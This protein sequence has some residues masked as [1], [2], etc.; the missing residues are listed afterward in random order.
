M[1]TPAYPWYARVSG[2]DLSQGDLLE[3]CPV[4]IPL[5]DLADWPLT[6]ANVRLVERDLVIMSQTCDLAA[7][8]LPE[9]L[10][11]SAWSRSELTGDLARP[12]MLENIRKGRYPAFHL[13]AACDLPGLER[14]VRLIDFRGTYAL[15]LAF[16]R[17]RA[18]AAGDRLRRLPPYREHLAQAFARFFM[19]VGLPID[20]PPFTRR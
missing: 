19:R 20:I 7:G 14:E 10:L 6:E 4:F 15:P 16:V 2:E 11:C 5:A 1:E 12:E 13:L 17:K 8:K 3:A 9:V 18:A